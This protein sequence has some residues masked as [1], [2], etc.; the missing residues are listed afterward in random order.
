MHMTNKEKEKKK[1]KEEKKNM[2]LYLALAGG[3]AQA[4]MGV[5]SFLKNAQFGTTKFL[6]SFLTVSKFDRFLRVFEILI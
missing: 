1:E 2:R 6:K 5:L 4:K 3:A